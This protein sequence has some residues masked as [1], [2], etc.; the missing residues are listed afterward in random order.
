MARVRAILRRVE[1]QGEQ[2]RLEISDLVIEADQ[3]RAFVNGQKINLT[4]KEAELLFL[5]AS[6]PSR[7][8]TREM[9]LDQLWGYD[10]YGDARTV[11]SHIKRLRAKLD[12]GHPGWD[13]STVR[14]RGYQFEL[15]DQAD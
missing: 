9:L 11:D 10:Y 6:N 13:I 2:K 4:V 8:Y 15:L 5:L 12:V 14:G 7:V 1:G 3:N